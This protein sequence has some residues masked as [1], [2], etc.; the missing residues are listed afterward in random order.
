MA[1][2]VLQDK[3]NDIMENV[4]F[5][6]IGQRVQDL[7]RRNPVALALAALTVGIAAGFLVR[8][9]SARRFMPDGDESFRWSGE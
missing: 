6:E 5:R 4:D 3:V 7:G 8:R 1:E 9:A 2:N